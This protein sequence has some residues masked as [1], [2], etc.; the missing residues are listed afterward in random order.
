MLTPKK[1]PKNGKNN[2]KL[3]LLMLFFMNTIVS[4]L[5]YIWSCGDLFSHN[6]PFFGF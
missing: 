2:S 1:L 4:D 3:L 5:P 6:N